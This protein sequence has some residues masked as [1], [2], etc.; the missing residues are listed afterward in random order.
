MNGGDQPLLSGLKP[1]E[2]RKSA[3]FR[4]RYMGLATDGEDIRLSSRKQTNDGTP[5][6]KL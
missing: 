1:R 6:A 5:G 2:P 4:L 3:L